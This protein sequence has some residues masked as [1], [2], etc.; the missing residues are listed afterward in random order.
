MTD[1]TDEE[2]DLGAESWSAAISGIVRFGTFFTTRAP[3]VLSGGGTRQTS[4]TV[5]SSATPA[6]E[7][8]FDRLEPLDVVSQCFHSGVTAGA[9]RAM[10]RYG[11]LGSDSRSLWGQPRLDQLSKQDQLSPQHCNASQPHH[12]R[13]HQ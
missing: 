13:S 7:P 8:I 6:R 2:F 11:Q 10:R 4:P 12:N 3:S 9:H 1:Q 5:D